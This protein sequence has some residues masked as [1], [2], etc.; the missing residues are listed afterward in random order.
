[1]VNPTGD[2]QFLFFLGEYWAGPIC[3]EPNSAPLRIL[4]LCLRIV[5]GT[6]KPDA[7]FFWYRRRLHQFADRSE[8]DCDLSD[9]ERGRAHACSAR[10]LRFPILTCA[11]DDYSAC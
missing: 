4:F 5:V 1:M 6:D 8:N 10:R 9:A 11:I 2:F 3:Q 7:T